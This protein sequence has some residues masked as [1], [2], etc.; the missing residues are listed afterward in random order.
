[1]W[2]NKPYINRRDWILENLSHLGLTP[3][4]LVVVLMIDYLNSNNTVIDLETLSKRCNMD[5]G[6][7]DEII[8]NLKRK[9]LIN[10]V[11]SKDKIDFTLDPLFNE[12][13]HYEYVDQS[14]FE[15]FESEFGRLLSQPELEQLNTW[16][17]H[18][19]QDEILSALRNAIVYQKV[20]MKYI[21]AIL[22]NKR[23]EL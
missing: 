2:W 22:V 8:H 16:L 13:V 9:N 19:T 14:I 5:V 17:A 23:N 18:Y 15:V 11:P 4:Q 21:N 3:D 6:N 7:V 10:I 12:G 20:S 1:M